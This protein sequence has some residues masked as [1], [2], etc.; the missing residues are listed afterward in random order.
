MRITMTTFT[1]TYMLGANMVTPYPIWHKTQTMYNIIIFVWHALLGL[2]TLFFCLR[3]FVWILIVPAREMRPRELLKA[4]S[5]SFLR[6]G[7]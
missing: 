4:L 2:I 7:C 1:L 6:A 3:L 5:S